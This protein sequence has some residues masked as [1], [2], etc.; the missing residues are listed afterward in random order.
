VIPGALADLP[1]VT[2]ERAEGARVVFA[3]ESNAEVGDL[4]ARV[5]TWGTLRDLTIAEPA[6]EDVISRLYTSPA[7]AV[8][9]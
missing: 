4:I 8:T 6:I 3:L 1:G 9:G 5:V 7:T 2:L